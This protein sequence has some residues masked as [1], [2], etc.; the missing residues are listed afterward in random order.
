MQYKWICVPKTYSK[1][2]TDSS[3]FWGSTWTKTWL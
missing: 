2:S 1:N 3:K